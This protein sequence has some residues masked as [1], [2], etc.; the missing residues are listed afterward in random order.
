MKGLNPQ[1]MGYNPEKNEGFEF[2][3][4]QLLTIPGMINPPSRSPNPPGRPRQ[5]SPT[6]AAGAAVALAAGGGEVGVFFGR[7]VMLGCP[8]GRWDQWLVIKWV[9]LINWAD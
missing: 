9:I 8:V 5:L 7:K 2:P 6:P 4:Y 3:W 1:Y